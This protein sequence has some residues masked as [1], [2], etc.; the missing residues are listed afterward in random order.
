MPTKTNGHRTR[1]PF[2]CNRCG[3]QLIANELFCNACSK[4]TLRVGR[5]TI[6]LLL[7]SGFFDVLLFRLTGHEW[8]AYAIVGIALVSFYGFAFSRH[9]AAPIGAIAIALITTAW[10]L[11]ALGIQPEAASWLEPIHDPLH[12]A[13]LSIVDTFFNNRGFVLLEI[14]ATSSFCGIGAGYSAGPPT[15]RAQLARY[16]GLAAFTSSIWG[17]IFITAASGS[18]ADQLFQL[19]LITAWVLP[20]A[21]L[22]YLLR[23][24]PTASDSNIALWSLIVGAYLT[25]AQLLMNGFEFAI[26][27]FA[28]QIIGRSSQDV[29]L[30]LIVTIMKWRSPVVAA[31]FATTFVSILSSSMTENLKIFKATDS[32][33]GRTSIGDELNRITSNVAR[34]SFVTAKH[35]GLQLFETVRYSAMYFARVI[36]MLLAPIALSSIISVCLFVS[37]HNL[38]VYVS[39]SSGQPNALV[40]FG[41]LG[42]VGV[43]AAGIGSILRAI[44]GAD[45]HLFVRDAV[46]INTAILIAAVLAEGAVL[47]LAPIIYLS[48][49][50]V[51]IEIA[52]LRPGPLTIIYWTTCGLIVISGA[53]SSLKPRISMLRSDTILAFWPSRGLPWPLAVI[54]FLSAIVLLLGVAPLANQIVRACQG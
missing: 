51:D 15:L 49:Q 25:P 48:L 18:G 43:V 12:S 26:E 52:A 41:E 22:I 11:F 19:A 16:L 13:T 29:H 2:E 50:E 14:V 36:Q 32:T 40:L 35:A 3:T 53:P 47:L 10:A 23:S 17:C 31:L 27:S 45:M 33:H 37:L 1:I 21:T 28:P 24:N 8:P 9:L 54:T 46:L 38:S 44:V 34:F 30:P 42:T 4:V 20:L 5:L 39:A 6:I 7:V